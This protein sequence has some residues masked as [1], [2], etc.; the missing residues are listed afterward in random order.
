MILFLKENVYNFL[1]YLY[2]FVF[3]LQAALGGKL[4]IIQDFV[5]LIIII[6]ITIIANFNLLSGSESFM[7]SLTEVKETP[8]KEKEIPF[9]IFQFIITAVI[10]IIII[11]IH[12]IK[13]KAI[14]NYYYYQYQQY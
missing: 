5:Y 1:I 12:F 11:I 4:V 2:Y 8:S 10:T 3:Y 6:I 7:Y 14:I 13:R 9:L